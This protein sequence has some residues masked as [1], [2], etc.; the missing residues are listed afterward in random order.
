MLL[1]YIVEKFPL[2]IP[3]ASLLSL[4]PLRSLDR[5]SVM[6]SSSSE[7][8]LLWLRHGPSQSLTLHALW[9]QLSPSTR[10]TSLTG[11]PSASFRSLK[12]AL[13]YLGLLHWRR[14]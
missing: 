8:G 3:S 7:R 2:F 10:S 1:I 5:Q 11:Q 6:T 4:R 14:F 13:F 9:N 12:T